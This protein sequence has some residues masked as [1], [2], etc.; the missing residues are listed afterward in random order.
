MRAHPAADT[1]VFAFFVHGSDIARIADIA[2][3]S[4]D[5]GGLKGFQ[6]KPIQS[7]VNAITEFLD[8]GPVLFPNAIILALSPEVDFKATRGGAAE[9]RYAPEFEAGTLTIPLRPAGSR[10][11]FI[12]DGQQRSLALAQAKDQHLAVPVIGFVSDDLE[13]QRT[14][15]IL[16]NKAKGLPSRLITELLPEVSEYLPRDLAAAQ[17]PSALV[18][19]LNLNPASPFYRLIRRASGDGEGVVTDSA[20]VEAIKQSLKM[21]GALGQF[22]R[23]GGGPDHDGMYRTLDLYWSAVKATFPEA[24]GKPPTESRLMHTA[25]IRAMSALMDQIMVRAEATPDPAAAVREALARIAP[26]CAWTEGAWEY[27]PEWNEI[28]ATPRDITRLSEHLLY[29]DRAAARGAR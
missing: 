3:L 5:E 8:S 27:G 11:A 20:L 2:R 21:Q 17:L 25:G 13:T 10:A 22:K 9:K 23:A 4:R 15:F 14:Q 6:R 12:V 26:V 28:Q 7:H 19:A 18:N 1:E 29:L 24:W 16:V